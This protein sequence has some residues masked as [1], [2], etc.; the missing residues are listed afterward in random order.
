MQVIAFLSHPSYTEL[1]DGADANEPIEQGYL[2][3][4]LDSANTEL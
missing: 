1:L 3:E 4:N 2:A